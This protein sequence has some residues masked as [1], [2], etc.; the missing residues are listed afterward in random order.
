MQKNPFKAIAV[1]IDEQAQKRAGE[2]VL[3]SWA[4][5]ELGTIVAGGLKLDNFSKI[6]TRFM[7]DDRLTLSEPD[8]TDTEV[9][10]GGGGYAEYAPHSHPVITPKQ[11]LP[12]HVGDR[13]LVAPVDGGQNFVVTNRIVPWGGD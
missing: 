13:V 10:S 4:A 7:V 2:A 1:V 3:Q 6:I 9:V 8:F 5:S 11:L 12:L